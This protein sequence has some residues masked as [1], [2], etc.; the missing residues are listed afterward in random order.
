MKK[1]DWRKIVST[2][3]LLTQ[4]GIVVIVNIGLAFYLGLKIDQWLEYDYIFKIIGLILGTGSG[5]YSV[6][7]LIKSYI[8]DD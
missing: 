7:Q 5:F 8:D 1:D 6:Y 2:M 4:L 3:A